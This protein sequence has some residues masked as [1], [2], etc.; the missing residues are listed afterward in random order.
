M[1]NVEPRPVIKLHPFIASRMQALVSLF[2]LLFLQWTNGVRGQ[3]E[4]SSSLEEEEE[5]LLP[6]VI[7]PGMGK[8][9]CYWLQGCHCV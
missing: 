4:D 3:S 2:L 8:R 1:A 9:R 6:L 7:W 5:E